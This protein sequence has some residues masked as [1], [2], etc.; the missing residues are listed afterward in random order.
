M[1]IK[2]FTPAEAKAAK[3]NSVPDEVFSAI[4]ELLSENYNRGAS[5]NLPQSKIV[6][7]IISQ[8]G[9]QVEYTDQEIREKIFAE[10]WLDFESV[11]EEAGWKVTYDKPGY[12]ESYAAFFIFKESSGSNRS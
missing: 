8:F 1:S 2:P 3:R 4:N 11:Y 12:N 10:H 9:D 7:R 6:D 5:I